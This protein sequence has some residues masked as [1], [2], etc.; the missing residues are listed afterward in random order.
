MRLA[1]SLCCQ[2]E[3]ADDLEG[4]D[5]DVEI[6]SKSGTLDGSRTGFTWYILRP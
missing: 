4:H 5:S 2:V 1:E 3:A 6:G